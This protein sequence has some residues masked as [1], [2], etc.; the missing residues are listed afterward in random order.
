MIASALTAKR[1]TIL[2]CLLHF[3][4]L[5]YTQTIAS[6]DFESGL[7]GWTDGGNDAGIESSTGYECGGSWAIY[8]K[9]DDTSN[10]YMT[11]PTYDLT[12]YT[13]I[14]I[15]FCHKSTSID[16]GE[17]FNLEFFDGT[18]WVT[19]KSYT[20][21]DDFNNNGT[22][23]SNSFMET[24]NSGIYTFAVNSRFRFTGTANGNGEKN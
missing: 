13:D 9:D 4:S 5:S 8:S 20:K 14:E 17:G 10:N 12:S 11:S 15:S 6:H 19:V 7:D 3:V 16:N 22:G 23:S 1:W 2:L 18:S 24:L 21:P